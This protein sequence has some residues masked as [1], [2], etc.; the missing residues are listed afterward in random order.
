MKHGENQQTSPTSE[1]CSV[2]AFK[3]DTALATTS[4]L[5]TPSAI[6]CTAA[7]CHVLVATVQTVVPLLARQCPDS[8][9]LGTWTHRCLANALLQWLNVWHASRTWQIATTFAFAMQQAQ[10]VTQVNL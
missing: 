3:L 7:P 4:M 1:A 9:E 2:C 6:H 5:Q 8:S 10:M